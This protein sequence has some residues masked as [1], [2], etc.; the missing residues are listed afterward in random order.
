MKWVVLGM[1]FLGLFSAGMSV[2]LAVTQ[3]MLK[4]EQERGDE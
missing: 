2:Y 4:C 3:P 1:I